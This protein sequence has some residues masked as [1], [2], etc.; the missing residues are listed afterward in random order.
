M[1]KILMYSGSLGSG[2]GY[3]TN[4]K[5]DILNSTGNRVLRLSFA[6]PIKKVID[7]TFGVNKFGEIID[8]RQFNSMTDPLVVTEEIEKNTTRYLYN[9]F[10]IPNQRPDFRPLA[11]T[12]VEFAYNYKMP[13]NIKT[14][15]RKMYQLY[16]TE[17]MQQHHLGIWPLIMVQTIKKIIDSNDLIDYILIDD[18]RYLSEYF[19][20]SGGLP[21]LK[22]IPYAITASKYVRMERLSVTDEEEFNNINKHRSEVEFSEIILP[23]MEYNFLDNII[24]N[25]INENLI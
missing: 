24:D 25:T 16:G 10:D 22:V 15:I 4:K 23:W 8:Q 7:K 5:T 19:I 9:N 21:N 17:Y 11:S 12:W 3:I 6:D 2:K 20:L 1:T 13:P 18:F 14:V